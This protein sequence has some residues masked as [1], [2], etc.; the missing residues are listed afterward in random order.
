M[1]D[2]A[3][4]LTA[5][6]PSPDPSRLLLR[7]D[8]RRWSIALERTLTPTSRSSRLQA[9]ARYRNVEVEAR[10]RRSD[11]TP[12]WRSV[13][14]GSPNWTVMGGDGFGLPAPRDLWHQSARP[15][16]AEGR[17]AWLETSFGPFG[18]L[19]SASAEDASFE[20]S[21]RRPRWNLALARL[22][23]DLGGA[24][25]LLCGGGRESE[26][27]LSIVRISE[28]H[29]RS[30]A[31]IRREQAW[32]DF[33]FRAEGRWD[34]SVRR[35]DA[36]ASRLSAPAALRF[37]RELLTSATSRRLSADLAMEWRARATALQP[38][39]ASDETRRWRFGARARRFG[40]RF[41]I[42]LARSH[43]DAQGRSETPFVAGTRTRD[44]R[45]TG[46]LA[47]QRDS[48][49]PV[50][51]GIEIG[52]EQRATNSGSWSGRWGG[53]WLEGRDRSFDWGIGLLE[54]SPA[55]ERTIGV[56]PRWT[57]GRRISVA[58]H[59]LLFG[60]RVR[61]NARFLRCDFK[62][63]GPLSPLAPPRFELT[64]AV[65]ADSETIPP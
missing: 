35:N 22:P 27:T 30:G 16:R 45:G 4:Y 38:G 19:A 5:V 34:E 50:R 54:V 63:V 39:A 12:G 62:A 60:L 6:L 57:G 20:L 55:P 8:P 32:N 48:G 42:R 26:W 28:T 37:R 15:R 59:S 2:L 46:R 47:V 31:R 7:E 64:L 65:K 29:L 53:A 49:A 25:L 36:R 11:T 9:E 56:A 51:P 52:I 40:A 43:T 24:Q 13:R 58:T 61:R 41:E 33:D 17:A 3:P 23:R 21:L 44:I 18:A 14:L 10:A 1:R